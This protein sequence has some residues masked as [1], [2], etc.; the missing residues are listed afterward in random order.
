MNKSEEG[1]DV[2]KKDK[3]FL[4]KYKSVLNSKTQ[5]DNLVSIC[6]ALPPDLHYPNYIH[7]Y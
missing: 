7:L 3:S 6:T 5:E 4:Q 2:T 1:G